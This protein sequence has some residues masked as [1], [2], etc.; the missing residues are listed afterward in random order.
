VLQWNLETSRAAIE[1]NL[2]T[3]NKTTAP[4]IIVTF[5]STYYRDLVWRKYITEKSLTVKNVF[6]Q[7]DI[8]ARVYIN[9]MLSP[10]KN[11]IKNEVIRRLVTP[12]LAA[13]FW[14]KKG[15]IFVARSSNPNE[16]PVQLANVPDVITCADAWKTPNA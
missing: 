14:I 9:L 15:S 6:P 11:K 4:M 16:R 8:D 12:G 10:H 2:Q 13:K 3:S 5:V 7:L 1:S